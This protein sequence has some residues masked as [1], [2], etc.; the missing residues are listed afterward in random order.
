MVAGA[1]FEPARGFE[2]W[3]AAPRP[4]FFQGG[5]VGFFLARHHDGPGAARLDSGSNAHRPNEFIDLPT[6][7]KVTACVAHNWERCTRAA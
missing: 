1:G 5:G 3:L 7:V 2:P 4:Q 6:S